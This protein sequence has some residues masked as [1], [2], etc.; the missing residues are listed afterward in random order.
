MA[1]CQDPAIDP[2]LRNIDDKAL[3]DRSCSKLVFSAISLKLNTISVDL[4]HSLTR[5]DCTLPDNNS[6]LDTRNSLH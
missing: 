1:E 6:F 2:P 4:Q 3:S 5:N